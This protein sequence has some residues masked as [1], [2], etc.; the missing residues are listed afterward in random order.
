MRDG[1]LWPSEVGLQGLIS[2]HPER[3]N[4]VVSVREKA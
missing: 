1:G 4:M 3:R 2:N